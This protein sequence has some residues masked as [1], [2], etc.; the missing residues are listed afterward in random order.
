VV[1][2][3]LKLRINRV[4]VQELVLVTIVIGVV[5]GLLLVQRH[6]FVQR[7]GPAPVL[8]VLS[9]EGVIVLFLSETRQR[10]V[11]VESVGSVVLAVM[12]S[13][14][15]LAGPFVV[16]APVVLIRIIPVS[17]NLSH[18]SLLSART[19]VNMVVP[20]YFIL[21]DVNG[22]QNAGNA[23]PVN[24]KPVMLRVIL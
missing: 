24:V 13:V 19:N 11:V 10:H 6:L 12:V 1:V 4:W 15:I 23:I 8:R 17:V 14:L 22:F 3:K 21:P 18:L 2:R 7:S 16:L 9:V 5:V 20:I